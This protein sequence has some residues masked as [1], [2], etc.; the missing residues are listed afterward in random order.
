M[1]TKFGVSYF[2][3]RVRQYVRTDLEEMAKS[4]FDY[5]VH[6]FSEN[7]WRYYEKSM[8][9][10]VAD[11]HDVGLKV[12]LDPWGVGGV[13][14]GEAFS[15]MVYKDPSLSQIMANGNWAPSACFN[16]NNFR[17]QIKEWISVGAELG[18]DCILWDE[19]HWYI[20][21]WYDR[22]DSEDGSW[23]CHCKKCEAKYFDLFGQPLPQE[24]NDDFKSFLDS[25]LFEFIEWV[26]NET[27]KKGM[28]NSVCLIPNEAYSSGIGDWEKII[29]LPQVD[30][31]GT[32][33][34]W[35]AH[36]Q[37]MDPYVNQY[38]E[39][40]SRLCDIH[41]KEAQVWVQ[42]FTIPEGHE[43]EVGMAAE[44]LLNQGIKNIGFWGYN[45]C[46]HMS[47]LRPDNPE[48]V[49]SQVTGTID[50]HINSSNGA[51]VETHI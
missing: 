16:N 34:Y 17:K 46:N 19:P 50:R 21:S 35:L 40:V 37:P 41:G 28:Q 11:S 9:E 24:L 13:F 51:P 45:A 8:A 14:G 2:G 3:N 23:V 36:G 12:V 26:T 27:K 43:E 38:A 30:T 29:S 18:A 25:S 44:I 39:K 48:K 49:W 4:G 31:F 15:Q 20:P 5:V 10:I 32:D 7:D 22:Q 47:K 1:K 6:T 33:P 42:A